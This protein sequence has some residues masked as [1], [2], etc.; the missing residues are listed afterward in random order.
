MELTAV[1]VIELTGDIHCQHQAILVFVKFKEPLPYF[2]AVMT[3]GFL[4]GTTLCQSE[5]NPCRPLVEHN[6]V[7]NLGGCRE[8][9]FQSPQLRD[10][11]A[12]FTGIWYQNPCHRFAIHESVVDTFLDLSLHV[13]QYLPAPPSQKGVTHTVIFCS[14]NPR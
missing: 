10:V 7:N 12:W 1:D 14:A 13:L 6:P 9:M 11:V 4:S 3:R 2:K 5:F 8:K